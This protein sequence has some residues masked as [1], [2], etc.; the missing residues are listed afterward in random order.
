MKLNNILN[1]SLIIALAALATGCGVGSSGGPSTP[2]PTLKSII[3]VTPSN[4]N[5][6]AGI[7]V[8]F[9]ATGT[10]SNNPTPQNVTSFVTWNSTNPSVASISNTPGKQGL[11]TWGSATGSS[12]ITASSG[13]L[14]ASTTLTVTPAQLV[15]I[16]VVPATSSIPTGTTEKYAATGKFSDNSSQNIST[17]VTWNSSRPD[18]AS[19][20]NTTGSQGIATSVA[21]GTTMIKAISGTAPGSALLTVTGGSPAFADNVIPITVNGSPCSNSYLNKP[22]VSVTV[23]TPGNLASCQPINDILL[24]TGSFGLRIFKQAL[25]SGVNPAQ[26][27]SD[28]GPPLAECVQFGDGSSL[29]GPVQSAD[30]ILG[31]EPAVQV[32]IQIVDSTFATARTACTNADQTPAAAGFNGI[33]G[34]GVFSY[35]CGSVCVNSANNGMYYSCPGSTCAGA[36]AQLTDQVQNPVAS[37]PT[38]SNGV[39]VELQSVPSGGS[40]SANGLLILGIGT[41]TNNTP[42][43]G[44]T[45]YPTDGFGEISTI[46][47]GTSYGSIIDSGSNGL[48]FV[49]PSTGML[50]NCASPNSNWFC[51]PSP[52]ILSAINAGATGSPSNAIFFQIGSLTALI[53]SSN[54]VSSSIGGALPNQSP[55][56]DWGL[57]FYLGRNIYVGINGKTSSL[58]S[59]PFIAY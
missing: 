55:L 12:L 50:P 28:S 42:P 56:F 49:P 20:S 9:T 21:S 32:P 1:P 43:G 41:R 54:S 13:S 6:A 26:I 23:C 16:T 18:V 17:T 35:D 34:L 48:F 47:N 4:P 25:P 44:V 14:S 53:G 31:N 40:P 7:P 29:W 36:A 10:L 8:Q 58:G 27:S 52:V 33:L 59:G 24:D 57:P 2:S 38:D 30:I 51:P 22:C 15:S 37:L 3:A 11:A 39:I 45:A 46:F 5:V 19:V